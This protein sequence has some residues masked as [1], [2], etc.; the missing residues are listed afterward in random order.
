MVQ[1]ARPKP[2]LL[3]PLLTN[4][5]NYLLRTPSPLLMATYLFVVRL[6]T[7]PHE[8]AGSSNAQPFD[9]PLRE[10]LPE[11]FFAMLTP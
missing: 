11:G 2:W 6:T 4:Q 8:L 9:E 7:H 10:N 5:I 3:E 1:L